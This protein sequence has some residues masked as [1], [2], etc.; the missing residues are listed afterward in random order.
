MLK[1]IESDNFYSQRYPKKKMEYLQYTLKNEARA[2][3]MASMLL[4]SWKKLKGW[5]K[6]SIKEINRCKT[7]RT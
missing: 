2:S 7:Y 4:G 6:E 5:L 3:A 1:Y